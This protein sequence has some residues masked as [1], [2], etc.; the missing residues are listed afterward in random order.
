M[1]RQPRGRAFTLIEIMVVVVLLGILAAIVFAQV[2][3]A[4]DSAKSSSIK[5]QLQTIRG[6]LELYY[7]QHAGSYPTLAQ[8]NA[9]WTVMT[10]KTDISGAVSASGAFGPYLQQPPRN[11]IQDS[12]SLAASPAVGVG[13]VYDETTGDIRACVPAAKASVL[14]LV[15]SDVSTY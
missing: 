12:A 13:W 11:P 4:T 2:S 8:L 3:G 14:G 10:G 9:N 5:S 15:S 7:T 1:I 6:Q